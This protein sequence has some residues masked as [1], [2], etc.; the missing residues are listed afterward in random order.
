MYPWYKPD[1]IPIQQSGN[2]QSSEYH[3]F[4]GE[5]KGGSFPLQKNAHHPEKAAIQEYRT[6]QTRLTPGYK[7]VQVV[8]ITEEKETFNFKPKFSPGSR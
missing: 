3:K 8:E 5:P 4:Y 6:S 1:N 7:R 2:P